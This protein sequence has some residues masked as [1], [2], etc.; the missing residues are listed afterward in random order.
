[1]SEVIQAPWDAQAGPKGPKCAQMIII[2]III[3]III[4]SKMGGS[5]P[6]AAEFQRGRGGARARARVRARALS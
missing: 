5:E 6:G 2:M 3:I 4:M 1:M